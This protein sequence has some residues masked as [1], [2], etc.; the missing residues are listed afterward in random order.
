MD[1]IK[2]ALRSRTTW[3]IV[4]LFV[5]NGVGAISSY[6]PVSV[7]PIIDGLLGLAIVYFHVNPSQ[8]YQI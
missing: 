3:T 1:R 4:A 6:I 8:N 7:K 2:L 5:I